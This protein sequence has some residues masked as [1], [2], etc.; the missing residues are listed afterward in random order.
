MIITITCI[1]QMCFMMKRQCL[2]IYYYE[3][4]SSFRFRSQGDSLRLSSRSLL[5]TLI[6]NVRNKKNRLL[7]PYKIGSCCFIEMTTLY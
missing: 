1:V 4:F 3:L 6:S 7:L 5:E 2:L